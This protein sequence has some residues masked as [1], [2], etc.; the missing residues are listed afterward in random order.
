[1][2]RASFG[3]DQSLAKAGAAINLDQSTAGATNPYVVQW[4]VLTYRSDG[5]EYAVGHCMYSSG[6]PPQTSVVNPILEQGA[7]YIVRRRS[8]FA[9]PRKSFF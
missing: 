9:T 5:T 3:K 8:T 4:R 2:T 7:N 1:V 6:V